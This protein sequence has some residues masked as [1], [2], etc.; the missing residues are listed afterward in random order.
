ML[1][2][3]TAA[4]QWQIQIWHIDR[5]IFYARNPRKNDAAG[6]LSAGV[7][8]SEAVA[9]PHPVMPVS[10]GFGGRVVGINSRQL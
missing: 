9:L 2:Q 8:K 1:S 7:R 3:E 5:L 6:E 10:N 4:Q